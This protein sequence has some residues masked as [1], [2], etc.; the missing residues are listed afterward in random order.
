MENKKCLKPPTSDA[1]GIYTWD[2]ASQNG[3][4]AIA[5]NRRN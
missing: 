5:K 2:L 4:I 3:E 1:L